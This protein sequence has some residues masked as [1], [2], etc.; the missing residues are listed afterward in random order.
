MVPKY[1]TSSSNDP[2]MTLPG[3][4]SKLPYVHH[5]L[6]RPIFFL[7]LFL[8][9]AYFDFPLGTKLNFI[10]LNFWEIS[11][12]FNLQD[13]QFFIDWSQLHKKLLVQYQFSNV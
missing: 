1:Q 12:S 6:W 11:Q 10:F 13:E 2:Q 7:L 5:V 8:I 3:Q 4:R 9:I